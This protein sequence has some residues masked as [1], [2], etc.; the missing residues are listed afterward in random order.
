MDKALDMRVLSVPQGHTIPSGATV[1]TEKISKE[2]GKVRENWSWL[3]SCSFHAYEALG[4]LRVSIHQS[5]LKAQA[6]HVR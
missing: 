4:K 3:F 2:K 5:S 1:I 6:R